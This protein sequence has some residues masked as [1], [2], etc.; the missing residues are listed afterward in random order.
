ML[1]AVCTPLPFHLYLSDAG[2]K[3]FSAFY[4]GPGKMD[5]FMHHDA[6]RG[7]LGAAGFGFCT[8]EE[9]KQK[10][11]AGLG[12]PVRG[13]EMAI[14]LKALA[15]ATNYVDGGAFW[16][17]GFEHFV[18]NTVSQRFHKGQPVLVNVG[19]KQSAL[20]VIRSVFR[21][22][23]TVEVDDDRRRA[24]AHSGVHAAQ[25]R[26]ATGRA[27]DA[28][29]ENTQS[30]FLEWLG[31]RIGP[32]PG[33]TCW[34][35]EVL[36][37]IQEEMAQKRSSA[38]KCSNH[39]RL[40]PGHEGLVTSFEVVCEAY[41][42]GIESKLALSGGGLGL[43]DA[44]ML[45][46]CNVYSGVLAAAAREARA[47]YAGLTHRFYNV[48]VRLAASAA[49]APECYKHLKATTGS[50]TTGLQDKEPGWERLVRGAIAAA[51]E[52]GGGGQLLGTH[53]LTSAG[54][55]SVK[56]AGPS[57]L[58][59]EGFRQPNHQRGGQ[60]EVQD[61]IIVRFVSAG[62]DS[63]GLHSAVFT[64][65]VSCVFPPMTQFTV[66]YVQLG[67]FEFDGTEAL[68]RLCKLHSGGRAPT[69]A[70]DTKGRARVGRA[71]LIEWLAENQ[72]D[73]SIDWF[74]E[75]MLPPGVDS[76]IYTVH[77]TLVTV[78]ATYLLPVAAAQAPSAASDA[79]CSAVPM[80]VA[81]AAGG[82]VHTKLMED[83]AK[84]VYG[85]RMTYIRGVVEIVF[86]RPLTMAEEWARNHRWEDWTGSS[87]CGQDEWD[88]VW[89]QQA[90]EKAL[91]GGTIFDQ[92]HGGWRLADFRQLYID[93]VAAAGGGDELVPTLEE[94][95]AA[96]LYTGP[97]YVKINDFMRLVGRVQTRHWRA[98]FAQL[99]G[100]TYSS[101]VYHLI[102]AV[103]KLT[104]IA[105]LL[106]ER[107]SEQQQVEADVL[108]RAVRG[109]LPSSFFE[110]DVQGFITAVDYG[111]TSTS[112][113]REVPVG[114]MVP[115]QYNVLWVMHCSHGA[116]SAGQLHNGAVLQPLSQFPAEAETLLPPLCMLQVLQVLRDGDPEEG[117]GTGVFRVADKEGTNNK[118]EAVQYKEIHV[119]PC[120][121]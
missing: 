35:V 25:L 12:Q 1:E 21:G 9:L 38:G 52:G 26:P 10:V 101:T 85:N 94:V 97:A 93:Q 32:D 60:T 107:G 24:V 81:A 16:G 13:E 119:R 105:T 112:A 114:F 15:C 36:L 22:C 83:S 96:R 95:A 58:A 50:Q 115:N 77:R 59:P 61:S 40:M 74:H 99:E 14:A 27:F 104:Q 18:T 80:L 91:P 90:K 42:Q 120:F 76:T 20:G 70:C 53:S 47:D 98:C 69:P 103:R 43:E 34:K 56:P 33:G 86:A 55:T 82:A 106:R 102:S 88:Y 73:G 108:Y 54:A 51:G 71:Q 111:F 84:L 3:L 65:Q 62:R 46:I 19:G 67:S 109:V 30:G 2:R 72:M 116:D 63:A 23:Y 110:P 7:D 64:D 17:G 78:R 92:G 87:F 41:K 39:P 68:L 5:S 117:A 121:V 79:T 8:A 4:T 37:V 48:L 75:N 66:N 49:S 28:A 45:T 113:K 118:G 29:Q 11:E 6:A 89:D 31:E 100:F 44:Q 57:N